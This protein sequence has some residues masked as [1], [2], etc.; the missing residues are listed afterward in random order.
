M[1]L[2]KKVIQY[3]ELLSLRKPKGLLAKA[4]AIIENK[5]SEFPSQFEGDL[6]LDSEDNTSI[7]KENILEPQHSTN[8]NLNNE[9]LDTDI[10]EESDIELTGDLGENISE[11]TFASDFFNEVSIDL[12]VEDSKE[13]ENGD[14]PKL[15]VENEINTEE[16][17]NASI[18]KIR[19]NIENENFSLDLQLDESIP[20]TVDID[21]NGEVEIYESEMEK[22]FDI[23][24]ELKREEVEILSAF[25]DTEDLKDVEEIFSESIEDGEDT[26]IVAIEDDESPFN[27]DELNNSDIEDICDDEL[28]N[29]K[30]QFLEDKNYINVS[31]S[32]LD[33]DFDEQPNIESDEMSDSNDQI[34]K[35]TDKSKEEKFSILNEIVENYYDKI[36]NI[37]KEMSVLILD[38]ETYN[39]FNSIIS[40][41]FNF[42]KSA[43][44]VYSPPDQKFILRSSNGLDHS[45][46]QTLNIDLTFNNIYKTMAKE[47]FL[48]IKNEPDSL[49]SLDKIISQKDIDESNF[50]LWIPFIFSGRIIG[51]FL[52]LKLETNRMPSNFLI[53]ALGI[54]GRLN[55]PL[56]YNIYQQ[57]SIRKQPNTTLISKKDQDSTAQNSDSKKKIDGIKPENIVTGEKK[58]IEEIVIELDDDDDDLK[59]SSQTGNKVIDANSLIENNTNTE[60]SHDSKGESELKTEF[61]ESDLHDDEKR[62]S[63][64]ANNEK[65]HTYLKDLDLDEVFPEK[66]HK[67][68]YFAKNSIE[69]SPNIT[70]SVIHIE[71]ANKEDLEKSVTDFKL[72]SFFG[73]IQ[74]VVMN[75]VGTNGF[76]QIYQDL[77]I[78]VVLPEIDT[79]MAK[80]IVKQ[81]TSEIKSMLNEIL[82]EMEITFNHRVVNYPESARDY[83]ELFYNVVDL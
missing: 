59:T 10:F 53:E 34:E 52:G 40:S 28:V 56:L 41:N 3:R 60:T 4:L 22:D 23:E 45:T 69:K 31:T 6:Y 74:F 61:I 5:N 15:L 18:E 19:K 24:D 81:I 21:E 64:E 20:N 16:D 39:K 55:G 7:L 49:S 13:A 51:V 42:T 58:V 37:S 47:K 46:C 79:N 11:D 71:F 44:L 76:V 62:D 9:D 73:D 80:E 68:I 17:T 78:Y 67:L 35:S 29:D 30:K 82:G 2:L 32:Q 43:L 75:I 65:V 27:F 70:L 66:L 33:A 14:E 54:I 48:F 25:E 63:N 50:Q 57:E 8:N 38:N 77:S 26:G 12:N 83:L 72:D 36:N 1:G